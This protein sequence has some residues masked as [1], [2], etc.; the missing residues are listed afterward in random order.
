MLGLAPLISEEGMVSVCG[1]ITKHRILLELRNTSFL[2]FVWVFFKMLKLS[3]FF[4][5]IGSKAVRHL[6]C[7]L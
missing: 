7:K 5:L 1:M 2:V 3:R 4:F 6:K